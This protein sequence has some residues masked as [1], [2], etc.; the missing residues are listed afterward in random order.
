MLYTCA[1]S[2]AV[3]RDLVPRL[4]TEAFVRSFKRSIARRGIPSLVVSENGSTFK[5]EEL[6][7]LLAEHNIDWKFNVALAPWWGGF[8]E[9][10]VRS[11]KR[12]LKKTLGTARI[13]CEE[14]HSVVV[15][16][17]VVV[18]IEGILNSRP[19]TYAIDYWL[20][21]VEF[22]TEKWRASDRK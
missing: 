13:S 4:T 12:C 1:S 11:T 9:R 10:L 3:H 19:L 22:R 16:V 7:K 20:S 2:R 18:E 17:V 6:K 15:V 14:L 21:T 8:F 5:S